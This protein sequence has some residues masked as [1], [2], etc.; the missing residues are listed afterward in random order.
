[1][2]CVQII[3]AIVTRLVSVVNEVSLPFSSTL[4]EL[5]ALML[6]PQASS[7]AV[8]TYAY[9]VGHKQARTPAVPALARV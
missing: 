6:G 9:V 5:D 7:P 1:M 4:E 8:V 2:S 3:G